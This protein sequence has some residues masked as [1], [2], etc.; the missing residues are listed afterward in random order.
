MIFN[1]AL[2]GAWQQNQRDG[3]ISGCMTHASKK[4]CECQQREWEKIYPTYAELSLVYN[5][6]PSVFNR[7]NNNIANKCVKKIYE[8]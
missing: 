2:F 7:Q 4:V 3:I 6:K 5:R 8:N 1:V